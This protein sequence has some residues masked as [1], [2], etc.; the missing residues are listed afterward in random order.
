MS[1]NLRAQHNAAGKGYCSSV[2]SRRRWIIGRWIGVCGRS[3]RKECAC[4]RPSWLSSLRA[5]I[6][7]V[8]REGGVEDQLDGFIVQR[9]VREGILNEGEGPRRPDRLRA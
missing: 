5:R 2:R 4:C 9:L 6:E 7:W 8:C 3:M 1:I